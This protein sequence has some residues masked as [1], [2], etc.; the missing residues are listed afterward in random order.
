MHPKKINSLTFSGQ[1]MTFQPNNPRD[2]IHHR[3][4]KKVARSKLSDDQPYFFQN[5]D[6]IALTKICLSHTPKVRNRERH[7]VRKRERDV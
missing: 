3:K 4:S 2:L 7:K 6:Q 1:K 5:W